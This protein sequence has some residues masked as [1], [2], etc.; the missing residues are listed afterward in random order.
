MEPRLDQVLVWLEQGRAVVRV[1]Y[2]DALGRLRH[3]TFYRPTGDLG[4]AL[5][6]VA[7]LLAEQGIEGQPR[8]RR[9]QGDRLLLERQLQ[10]RF[11]NAL[12]D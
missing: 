2:F 10:A 12:K 7:Y 6:E 4:Q 1:E 5:E 8:V 11:W 9:K 3:Q